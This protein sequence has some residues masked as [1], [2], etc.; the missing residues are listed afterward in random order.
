MR[1]W[2]PVLVTVLVLAV[3]AVVIPA[4]AAMGA[5]DRHLNVAEVPSCPA[6]VAER[7]P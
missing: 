4:R 6:V 1:S 5:A 7:A 2:L 3:G